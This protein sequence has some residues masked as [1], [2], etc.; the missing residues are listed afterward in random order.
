MPAWLSAS[1]RKQDVLHA[2]K[3]IPIEVWNSVAWSF[4]ALASCRRENLKSCQYIIEK[5]NRGKY[6]VLL[7]D[8]LPSPHFEDSKT[9][10][11]VVVGRL[12]VR[13]GTSQISDVVEVVSELWNFS[14]QSY[15]QMPNLLSLWMPGFAKLELVQGRGVFQIK[16]RS[17]WYY[18]I[19]PGG[20]GSHVAAEF[21]AEDVELLMLRHRS[22]L[23]RNG[24]YR[25]QNIDILMS[26]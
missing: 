3:Y 19:S 11:D 7:L 16:S 9:R 15:H 13:E 12:M 18:T 5:I 4:H 2:R 14:A 10:S 23:G 17:T 21:N 1:N 22:I 26:R 24:V 20:N 6:Q 25:M 8:P